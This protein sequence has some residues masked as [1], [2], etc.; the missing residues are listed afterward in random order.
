MKRAGAVDLLRVTDLSATALED[1]LTTMLG[2]QEAGRHQLTGRRRL[3]LDGLATVPLLA[4]E[5]LDDT[6][7]APTTCLTH[8]TSHA[9]SLTRMEIP[10]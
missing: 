3:R 1:R 2:D 7:N 5:L 8:L 4:A 9:T 6:N 10:A